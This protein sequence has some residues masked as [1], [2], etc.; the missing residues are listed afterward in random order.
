MTK[1]ARNRIGAFVLVAL[2]AVA[3]GDL[4]SN[5]GDAQPS[6]DFAQGQKEWKAP[7]IGAVEVSSASE[8]T[9]HLAFTPREPN[10]LGKASKIYAQNSGPESE[11]QFRG[12][13][14]VFETDQY[15]VIRLSMELDTLTADQRAS[16]NAQAVARS[17]DP[18]QQGRGRAEFVTIRGGTQALLGF[19]P[20]GSGNIS[21]REG[22]ILIVVA[23]PALTR[24][25]AIAIAEKL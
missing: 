12:L 1:V 15:G 24:E 8:A 16:S 13:V 9:R 2:G 25:Q 22:P 21:W 20:D 5:V 10:G 11:R 19:P 7:P 14:W 17:N 18:N 23:G 4:R 3:C 6:P